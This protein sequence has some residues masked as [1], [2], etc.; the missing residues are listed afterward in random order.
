MA[1]PPRV[2]LGRFGLVGLDREIAET[3]VEI[4]QAHG[5]KLPDAIVRTSARCQ[6]RLLVTRDVKDFP[7]GEPVVRA[8]HVVMR[9]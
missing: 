7:P 6:G 2:F 3:A 5:M 1:D 4:R 9:G 8:P